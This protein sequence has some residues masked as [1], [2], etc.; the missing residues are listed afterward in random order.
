MAL[1]LWKKEE[2]NQE[3]GKREL[4]CSF[5]YNT[6]QNLPL[7]NSLDMD[8]WGYYIT[9]PIAVTEASFLPIRYWVMLFPEPTLLRTGPARA[10]IC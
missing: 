3:T 7:R 1:Q 4:L 5:G 8:H 10:P 2:A 6:Q 9:V